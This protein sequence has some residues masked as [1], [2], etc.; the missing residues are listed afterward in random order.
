MRLPRD[1]SGSQLIKALKRLG[2]QPTR[3][4]GSHVRLTTQ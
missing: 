3:Q 4:T 1:L 2:Y